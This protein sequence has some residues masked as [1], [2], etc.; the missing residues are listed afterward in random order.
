MYGQLKDG[1]SPEAMP[2]P[3]E[4][5]VPFTSGAAVGAWELLGRMSEASGNN[6]PWPRE[7]GVG[8]RPNRVEEMTD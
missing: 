7:R 2:P 1:G 5:A 8:A 6:G 4:A 3:V